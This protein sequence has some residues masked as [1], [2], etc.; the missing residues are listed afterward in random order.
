MGL[1]FL[2][3]EYKVVTNTDQAGP[4]E[5]AASRFEKPEADNRR[6]EQLK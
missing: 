3:A 5:R 1:P 4:R 2:S 6:W